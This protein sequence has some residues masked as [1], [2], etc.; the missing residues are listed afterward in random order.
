MRTALRTRLLADAT[1]AGLLGQNVAWDDRPRAGGL[2]ALM[3]TQIAP[4][5]DY[6]HDGP[7]G[8]DFPWV[9]FDL[10]AESAQS[11]DAIATALLA[12]MESGATAGGVR[13]HP[14]FLEGD[15]G[16]PSEVLDGNLDVKHRIME[17]RFHWETV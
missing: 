8:L 17:F 9:Q 14:G 5:R 12:E 4:G 6:T 11:I 15:R 2:P 13:F 3:L 16:M 1:L 7:D 10:F